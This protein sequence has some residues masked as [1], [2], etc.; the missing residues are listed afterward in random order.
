MAAWRSHLFAALRHPVEPKILLL[1][2]D[3]AWRLPHAFV[4]EGVWVANAQAVVSAFEE[5]LG[6]K[7]WLLRQLRFAQDDD[8]KRIDAVYELELVDHA[9]EQPA[10]G[11]WTGRADLDRLPLKDEEQRE[12]LCAYLDGLAQGEVPEERPPWARPGWLEEVRAWLEEEVARLG[13]AVVGVEQVKHWS[14]SSVLRVRTDGPDL[15]FKVPARLPLFVEEGEVTARLAERFPGYVPAPIVLEPERGWLLLPAFGELFGWDAPLETRC[16]MLSRFAG[17]QRRTADLTAELLADG[18]LDRRLGVLEAQI[19]PLLEDPEAVSRL[20]AEEVAALHVLAPRLKEICRRLAAFNVPATLVHGDLH[21]LNVARI[22]GE[23]AYF[24]WTD[25]CVAHPFIDLLSLQ[26]ERDDSD[27]TALLEAYLE[28]WRDLEP[29]ERLLEAVALA[30]VVI[31]LHHA[32]SYQR[33]VAGLEP[34]AKPELDA[35]H[36]FLREVLAREKQL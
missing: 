13:H 28:P 7:P 3:R 20:T 30:A 17:L 36:Q 34:A 22:D 18:C 31:P 14:I 26:W 25:A 21:L 12:L 16:E 10:H 19:D 15:Y 35:T 29:P 9:W 23:L 27:R 4:R 8:A 24:D 6:T 11:R 2:S 33:I 1:R 32:V 5:R